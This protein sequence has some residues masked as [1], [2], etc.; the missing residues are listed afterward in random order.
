MR[1]NI[2]V[3]CN[4]LKHFSEWVHDFSPDKGFIDSHYNKNTFTVEYEEVVVKYYAFTSRMDKNI[5]LGTYYKK[6]IDLIGLSDNELLFFNYFVRSS[7]G[8]L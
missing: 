3:L 2:L 4:N 6:I 8:K 1:N 5:L 7:N